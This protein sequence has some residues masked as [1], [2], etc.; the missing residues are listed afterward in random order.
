M[1]PSSLHLTAPTG[2]NIDGGTAPMY[3][4][5]DKYSGREVGDDVPAG[6]VTVSDEHCFRHISGS[7][8][9]ESTL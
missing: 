6:K 8:Q 7:V 2:R 5:D 4:R 9:Q 3:P 1:N